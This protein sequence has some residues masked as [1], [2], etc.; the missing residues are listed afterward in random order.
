MFLVD[1]A[2]SDNGSVLVASGANSFSSMEQLLDF[3]QRG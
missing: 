1:S 2:L 3:L